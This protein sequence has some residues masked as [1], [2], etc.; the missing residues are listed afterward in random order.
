MVSDRP[1]PLALLPYR[2]RTAE[3]KSSAMSFSPRRIVRRVFAVR[4]FFPAEGF[5]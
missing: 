1:L 5:D 3:E 4:E 2:R